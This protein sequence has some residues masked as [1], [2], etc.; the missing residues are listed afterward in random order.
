M[1]KGS[2]INQDGKTN[3]I[4]AP[5]GNAQ[6]SL[7]KEV[8]DR[9]GINPGDITYIEAHG[10]GTK[11]GDPIEVNALIEAFSSYT[12]K[13]RYCALGSVKT[14]I[15]HALS[16]AGVAS[17]IKCCFA[18]NSKTRAF[19][20]FVENEHINFKDSPFYVNTE[21]K[22]WV[23]ENNKR[24]GGNYSASAHQCHIV[25]SE[26]PVAR[27]SD[28]AALPLLRYLFPQNKGLP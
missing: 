3:G 2:A 25:V 7:E 17:L 14:V 16:A 13:K 19:L 12:S 15:G 1:I 27:T 8:Y 24:N 5:S 4:S 21:L 9:F 11:L 28:S 26:T 22:E 6:A 20:N 18:L 10:T 23:G